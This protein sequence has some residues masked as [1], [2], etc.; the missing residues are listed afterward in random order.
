[1][2]IRTSRSM[3]L[4]IALVVRRGSS[5]SVLVRSNILLFK[6]IHV[7]LLLLGLLS[8][9]SFELG[10]GGVVVVGG[11]RILTHIV[12]LVRQLGEFLFLLLPLA[13]SF[14]ILL[15][16]LF[17]LGDA[18]LLGFLYGFLQ[19]GLPLYH[20]V[21]YVDD[22]GEHQ[23]E[24][25]CHQSK[26]SYCLDVD[27]GSGIREDEDEDD[28][29]RVEGLIGEDVAVHHWSLEWLCGHHVENVGMRS[30]QNE[31]VLQEDELGGD[32]QSQQD[33]RDQSPSEEE[34]HVD[35]SPLVVLVYLE[36]EGVVVL[37]GFFVL[38]QLESLQDQ[39]HEEDGSYDRDDEED[40]RTE[41]G[42]LPYRCRV[43]LVL[44][45]HHAEERK[46]E[47]HQ[48]KEPYIHIEL[49]LTQS[50]TQE[51]TKSCGTASAAERQ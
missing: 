38:E 13:L 19:L 12:C 15:P 24:D 14:F 41:Q 32:G 45:L 8:L 49:E 5:R 1:M 29:C 33:R 18:L 16:L 44:D 43:V 40:V 31:H 6:G 20:V 50:T 48:H 7:V 25:G 17:F 26:C 27:L 35:H 3:Q 28:E 30:D 23:E 37:L 51:T 22:I 10:H 34:R 42:N 9:L 2:R 21:D 4:L 46:V 47:V 11:V 36:D 39:S